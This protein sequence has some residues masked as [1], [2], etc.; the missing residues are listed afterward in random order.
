MSLEQDIYL[1]NLRYLQYRPAL[2]KVT[3][4]NLSLKREEKE[5]ALN[6]PEFEQS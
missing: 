3:H 2:K 4:T 6:H 5:K 1:L